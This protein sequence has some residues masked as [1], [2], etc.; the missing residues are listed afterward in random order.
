MP[1]PYVKGFSI[2]GPPPCVL[3]MIIEYYTARA[4]PRQAEAPYRMLRIAA[5]TGIITKE[6]RVLM[7]TPP[8]A[9]STS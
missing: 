6:A 9:Y 5:Y 1:S 2:S 7:T 4:Y 3:K 8:V